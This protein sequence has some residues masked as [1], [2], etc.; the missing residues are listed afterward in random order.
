VIANKTPKSRTRLTLAAGTCIASLLI[1]A[2]AHAGDLPQFKTHTITD[3]IKF[4][5]QLVAADLNGDGKKDLIAIDERATE[6]AWFE[7]PSWNR[8]VLA[9]D[10]PRPLNAACHDID[11]DGI[12]EVVLAYRFESR[13]EESEGNVVLLKSGPDVRQPWIPREIDRVPTAHRVR[14]IDPEGD[15]NKVLLLG[16]MVGKRYPPQEGD[17]VPIYLYRPGDWKRETITQEPGGVLHAIYPV[18]WDDTPGQQ[19]L[20]ASFLGLHR[21]QFTPTRS[22]SRQTLDAPQSSSQ[23]RQTLDA[24][25]N[26]SRSRQTLALPE[27]QWNVTRLSPGD[28]RPWPQCGSSEVRL[29]HL[30]KQR[31]LATIEPWHGNQVV[32][33]T[34][35][36]KQ[37]TRT[38]IEDQMQNGHA[39]AVGDLDG[40]DQDEIVCGFRGKGH[41]L[42]IYQATD[43]QAKHWR[44]TILD[45]GGMAG[46]D[47]LIEDLTADG[48]P[49]IVCIGASTGNVK[50]YENLAP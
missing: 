34:P 44:K 43:T 26:S 16:P 8:H 17:R 13:P 22:R 27:S 14:W 49:D 19:L 33:Y 38:V 24:P 36:G 47:C 9:T 32:V 21:F 29:G 1:A 31:F 35:D 7:N 10:V 4:G 11:S 15:G 30:G 18:T 40:D 6:L 3:S 20:T 45:N 48:R 25:Q 5:Y 12:P 50:L 42:S 41:H 28:P 39:L 46:A 2:T 23:S 37:W